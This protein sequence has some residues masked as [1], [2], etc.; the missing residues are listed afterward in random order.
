[1]RQYLSD[2]SNYTR[3]TMKKHPVT[4]QSNDGYRSGWHNGAVSSMYSWSDSLHTTFGCVVCHSSRLRFVGHVN[5]VFHTCSFPNVSSVED[6]LSWTTSR[7]TQEVV[8]KKGTWED[9]KTPYWVS[10]FPNKFK[11]PI[12]DD[13]VL[14]CNE[15]WG[16]ILCNDIYGAPNL[17]TATIITVDQLETIFDYRP[18][19]RYIQEMKAIP[20]Y[21]GNHD[22]QPALVR[23]HVIKTVAA[24]NYGEVFA[25][26]DNPFKLLMDFV[27]NIKDM[28]YDGAFIAYGVSVIRRLSLSRQHPTE[29]SSELQ[30]MVIDFAP[31]AK[32]YGT[33]TVCRVLKVGASNNSV[34]IVDRDHPFA[35]LHIDSVTELRQI[36][37]TLC[38][39]FSPYSPINFQPSSLLTCAHRISALTV[40][41][42][43]SGGFN[44]GVTSTVMQ[45]VKLANLRVNNMQSIIEDMHKKLADKQWVY[46]S[47]VTAIPD[48]VADSNNNMKIEKGIALSREK[49]EKAGKKDAAPVTENVYLPSLLSNFPL[50]MT[51]QYSKK[52]PNGVL[53]KFMLVNTYNERVPLKIVIPDMFKPFVDIVVTDKK[54]PKDSTPFYSVADYDYLKENNSSL[55]NA[56]HP[57]LPYYAQFGAAYLV[58][59]V[60][61]ALLWV[62]RLDFK[63]HVLDIPF[64]SDSRGSFSDEMTRAFELIR[65]KKGR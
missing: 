60:Y 10:F 43:S 1:M 54:V 35:V 45:L 61:D 11:K 23:T 16:V 19:L 26:T 12:L 2:P 53:L 46:S 57:T 62:T 30:N 39:S 7:S 14:A 44:K 3:I 51:A 8:S 38:K 41:V 48:S 13:K 5:Y 55:L 59:T 20:D 37:F 15:S 65:Y 32:S 49:W 50:D 24:N 34:C 6:L 21:T 52:Y 27:S 58:S 47:I 31:S 64:V 40:G 33:I 25:R 63:S 17:S 22:A 42:Q 28:S 29:I 56:P 18:V 9:N 4:I 36:L